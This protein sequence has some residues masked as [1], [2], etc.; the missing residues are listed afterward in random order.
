MAH[1]PPSE[2]AEGRRKLAAKGHALPDGSFPIPNV[3]Y[4]KKAIQAFGRAKNPAAAKAHIIRRARAL[5]RADLIPPKWLNK[6]TDLGRGMDHSSKVH[7]GLDRS[8]KENWVDEE[9]GLPPYIDRIAKHLESDQHMS[10]EEAIATAVNT[11]KKMCATGDLNFPGKQNVNAGSRA[12]ACNAVRQWEK[13]KA[14]RGIGRSSKKVVPKGKP[15]DLSRSIDLAAGS[16]VGKTVRT[17]AGARRFGVPI[18]TVVTRD[19]EEQMKKRMEHNKRMRMQQRAQ[20]PAKASAVPQQTVANRKL[21]TSRALQ[22]QA[23]QG[24]TGAAAKLGM[25]RPMPGS[26]GVNPINAPSDQ[27][28]TQITQILKKHRGSVVAALENPAVKNV[29]LTIP[30]FGTLVVSKELAADLLGFDLKKDKKKKEV[31]KK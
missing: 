23:R 15:R 9:G 31:V 8:P 4:L 27:Q 13:M 5:G 2:T 22:T 1:T 25:G 6:K 28:R 24:V 29:Q 26:S 21:A 18:G 11:A 10:R 7:P 14:N 20:R 3:A 12:E 30:G 19:L 17:E 16:M